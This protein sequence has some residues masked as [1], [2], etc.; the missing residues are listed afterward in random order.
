MSQPITLATFLNGQV[1]AADVANYVEKAIIKQG[2]PS[3]DESGENCLY[4]GE[5]NT[6]CAAGMLITDEQ[7]DPA[8]DENGKNAIPYVLVTFRD[9]LGLNSAYGGEYGNTKLPV[10]TGLQKVHDRAA[11]YANAGRGTF[12]ELYV[13]FMSNFRVEYA[14]LL[15][16]S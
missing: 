5:C 10:I 8:M 16:E 12:V 1:S 14:K 3:V 9:K 15:G 13:E 11:R 7:Y 4:R 2:R 6:K